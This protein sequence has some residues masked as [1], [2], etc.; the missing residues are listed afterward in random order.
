[1]LLTWLTLW[2]L[3]YPLNLADHA[4][5][6]WLAIGPLH[7]LDSVG[8]LLIVGPLAMLAAWRSMSQKR[9]P[10]RAMAMAVGL[11]AAVSL[12]GETVQVYLPERRSSLADFLLNVISAG[13]FAG[14]GIW[15]SPRL[16]AISMR[17]RTRLARC[18]LLARWVGFGLILLAIRWF[19]FGL[20]PQSREVRLAL[21]RAWQAG[22]PFAKSW[23]AIHGAGWSSAATELM[24]AAIALVVW[25]I[26]AW[27][28]GRALRERYPSERRR[29]IDLIL[30]LGL[31]AIG[32]VE[33]FRLLIDGIAF[34]LT[35]L[36]SAAIGLMIGAAV[37]S[38]ISPKRSG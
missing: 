23:N 3:V 18:P 28:L 33:P 34:S 1:M 12:V 14:L 10:W 35:D 27:L 16:S 19:P 2:E 11:G 7:K 25:A 20:A 13:A 38:A 4:L 30:L 22:W 5:H 32:I 17:Y 26:W 24:A 31:T 36:V 37:E 15:W 9:S 6:R 21:Q 29:W 8:N